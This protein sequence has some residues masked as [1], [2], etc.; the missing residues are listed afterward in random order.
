MYLQTSILSLSAIA[1]HRNIDVKA[2]IDL[3]EDRE[4]ELKKVLFPYMKI[5][6]RREAEKV[7]E[8]E[9]WAQLDA[10]AAKKAAENG[11][12]QESARDSV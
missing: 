10:I 9:I 12:A 5:S 2:A 11:K 1:S 4:A 7:N 6:S 3:R 8:D